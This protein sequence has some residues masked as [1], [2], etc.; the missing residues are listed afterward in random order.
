MENFNIVLGENILREC[1]D[2]NMKAEIMVESF[3]E[4]KIRK[5]CIKG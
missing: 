5:V 2:I 3:Q 4:S 1:I